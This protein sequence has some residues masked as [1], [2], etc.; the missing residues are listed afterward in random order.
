MRTGWSEGRVFRRGNVWWIAYYYNGKENRESAG[1]TE[2]LAKAKLK[3]RIRQIRGDRF[4]GP[5]QERWT[6]GELLDGLL[7]HLTIKGAK[8]MVPLYSHLRPVREFF[9]MTR[10]VDVTT[11]LIEQYQHERLGKG[12]ATATIN[13][14]VGALRQALN[15]ARKQG[16]GSRECRTSRCC[17]RTTFGRGS[18]SATSS[19]P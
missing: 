8:G 15:L 19:R 18:S 7:T 3:E 4:V 13:R 6:V 1:K 17:G 5:E 12:K 10:A 14:E 9:A 16:D 2:K 11:A